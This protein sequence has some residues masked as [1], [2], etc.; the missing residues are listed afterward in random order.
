V[1]DEEKQR[2][3]EA[4]EKLGTHEVMRRLSE[5]SGEP[6]GLP[7]PLQGSEIVVHPKYKFAHLYDPEPLPPADTELV[8]SWFSSRLRRQVCVY[9]H[10]GNL[11]GHVYVDNHPL[12]MQ[13]ETMSVSAAWSVEMETKALEKLFTLIKEPARSYYV[14]TGSF[15]ETSRRSGITYLFRKLRPTVALSF[16]SG[17]C[18]ALCGLCMH[19]IGYYKK[20]WGGCLCPT[21]DVIAHLMLMRGDEHRYWRQANQHQPDRPEAG[22]N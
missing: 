16:R 9:C 4:I 8:N 17:E 1:T 13:I 19:P 2:A 6:C 11:H 12:L 5:A 3:Q 15:L 20:T 21:D 18:K 7:C 10:E 22:I 14:L